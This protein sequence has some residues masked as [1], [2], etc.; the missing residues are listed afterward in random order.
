ML[1]IIDFSYSKANLNSS[2]LTKVQKEFLNNALDECDSLAVSGFQE[3]IG[4]LGRK[5]ILSMGGHHDNGRF[6]VNSFG[7]KRG[8]KHT[9][10][11]FG[12]IMIDCG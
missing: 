12:R 11:K 4:Y 7:F 3:V 5:A 10:T 9:Y 8:N 1:S 6:L 2:K